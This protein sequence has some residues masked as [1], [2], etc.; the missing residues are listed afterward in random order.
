[1]PQQPAVL[2]IGPSV[3]DSGWAPIREHME[4]IERRAAQR[5]RLDVPISVRR[6]PTLRDTDVLNGKVRNISTGGIY[7]TA[8]RRLEA[9]EV[10][11]FSL[12]L[13]RLVEGTDIVVR[14]RAR[15]LRVVQKPET[16]S[17]LAG[18]A[19]IIEDF[20]IRKDEPGCP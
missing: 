19:A 10:V 4:I 2:G 12:T 6:V 5:Y 11:D 13:A 16:I 14:G 8:D 18:V 15:V 20:D 1:M 17:G 7:F 9:D 3:P